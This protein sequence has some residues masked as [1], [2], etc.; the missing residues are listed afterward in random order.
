MAKMFEITKENIKF[1]RRVEE[2]ENVSKF[3]NLQC[4]SRCFSLLKLVVSFV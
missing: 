3:S 4:V 2:L 1:G